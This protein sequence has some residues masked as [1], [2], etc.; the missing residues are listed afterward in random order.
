MLKCEFTVQSLMGHA[1]TDQQRYQR[2]E[3]VCRAD[4]SHCSNTSSARSWR[5]RRSVGA[6][7]E[8]TVFK[9]RTST[10]KRAPERQSD[11]LEFAAIEYGTTRAAVTITY[12]KPNTIAIE[13]YAPY[14][15]STTDYTTTS[16]N[17]NP[18][19]CRKCFPAEKST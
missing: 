17:R 5:S 19:S 4:I 14:F 16:I 11:R 1:L 2:P 9:D 3:E 6:D 12:R 10:V 15:P 8:S 18:S 7:F 13:P